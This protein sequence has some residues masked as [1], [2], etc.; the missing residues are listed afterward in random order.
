MI[1]PLPTQ[2]KNEHIVKLKRGILSIPPTMLSSNTCTSLSYEAK[3]MI[4]DLSEIVSKYINDN[5]KTIR[6]H[7]EAQFQNHSF[8][9]KKELEES[10]GR[11]KKALNIFLNESIDGF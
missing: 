3:A 1:L 6:N 5:C 4:E 9:N 7:L 8:K 11:L 10:I 2:L